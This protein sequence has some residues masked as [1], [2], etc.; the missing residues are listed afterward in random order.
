MSVGREPSGSGKL[1]ISPVKCA[2]CSRV[3]QNGTLHSG[4]PYQS[5]DVSDVRL[6]SVDNSGAM[7]GSKPASVAPTLGKSR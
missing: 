2:S 7:R 3:S 4:A 5:A 1:F 6:L